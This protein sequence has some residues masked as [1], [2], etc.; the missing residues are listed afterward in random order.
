MKVFLSHSTKDKEF[1]QQLAK[2]MEAAGFDAWRCE[3]SIQAQADWIEEIEKGL[4]AADIVL[5]VWSPDAAASYPTML[6]YRAALAREIIVKRMRLGVVLLRDWEL[7]ELLLT[8]QYIDARS[9]SAKA[10]AS[11]LDWLKGRRDLGRLAGMRNPVFLEEYPSDDFFVGRTNYLA[12][13]R[14]GFFQQAISYLLHGEPGTGKTTLAL[15]FA[16]EAQKDFDAV[17]FQRC[18]QRS[19]DVLAGELAYKLREQLGEEV[20]A[21]PPE[22]KLAAVAEWLRGRQSLL[23]LD[24]VWSEDV[25]QLEP[26]APCSVLFTSRMQS[27]PW[28]HD[29]HT[30]DVKSFSKEECEAL[31]HTTLDGKLGATQVNEHGEALTGFAQSM[32]MLPIAV[33]VGASLLRKNWAIGLEKGLK[34]L[35]P[36]ALTY[37][38]NVPELFRKAIEAQDERERSLLN[39]AAVCVQEGFWLQL[40]ARIAGLSEEEAE[41]AASALVFNSLMR[42]AEI[43]RQPNMEDEPP[44]RQRF[45]MHALLRDQARVKLGEDGLKALQERHAA[46]LEKLF[47][48]WETRLQDAKVTVEETIPA[49]TFLWSQHAA[50]RANALTD[51]SHLFSYRTGELDAAFR[52][53]KVAEHLPTD[54]D[55]QSRKPALAGIYGNQAVILADWG[56]LE[57]ALELHRKEE[58]ICREL[59]DRLGLAMT[60]GNRARILLLGDRLEE[61]LEL[62]KEVAAI[63][64]ERGDKNLLAKTYGNQA[65]VLYA[66]GRLE[67]ALKLLKKEETIYREV[68][69]QD[70]LQSSYYSRALILQER[71]RLEEALELLKEQEAIC[72]ELNN[73]CGLGSCYWRWGLVAGAQG[74]HQTEKQKLQEALALFTELN[75]PHE[76]DAVQAELE[77]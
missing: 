25:K 27:L 19:I 51:W 61:A 14:A 11:I 6:E 30:V 60:F 52:V 8:R 75:M 38:G 12:Q 45:Q 31:F 28:I 32:E 5:L 54:A 36:E 58:A 4:K 29:S 37:G 63:A 74:D 59:G 66:W 67:E 56:R 23:V 33:A 46:E 15:R 35:K 76:R 41:D 40:A 34:R 55:D 64:T 47:K 50:A 13:L 65:N 44:D 21:L 77:K 16:W 20:T 71:G 9:D 69:N 26:G 62:L 49:I 70:G 68:G 1:V 48:D 72:L 10:I 57:E 7:P 73:K 3:D 24:D 42:K 22:K 53:L 39:A 43:A 17:I 18:G 2:A